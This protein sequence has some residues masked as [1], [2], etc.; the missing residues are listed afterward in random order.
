MKLNT[1]GPSY[2]FGTRF[3]DRRVPPTVT[4]PD[5]TRF[6]SALRSKPHLKP[7]KVDGPGPGDYALPDSV[8]VKKRAPA[9]AQIS[10]WGTGREKDHSPNK[11]TSGNFTMPGPAHY[12]HVYSDIRQFQKPHQAMGYTFPQSD[13]DKKPTPPNQNPGPGNYDPQLP[14]SGTAKS[15]LGGPEK[16]KDKHNG[17]PSPGRH[18]PKYPKEAPSWIIGPDKRNSDGKGDK[19]KV[20]KNDPMVMLGPDK[21]TPIHV[22]HTSKSAAFPM[23]AKGGKGPAV[24]DGTE[25]SAKI[26]NV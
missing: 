17:V 3:D 9:S 16:K 6:D 8:V 26:R 2:Q 25:L 22:T 1:G 23:A 4:K 13:I 15:M 21:Y 20:I 18:S 5:G 24:D 14:K 7:K 10:T 12:N 19:P 11:N